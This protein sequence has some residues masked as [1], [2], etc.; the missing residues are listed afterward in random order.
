MSFSGLVQWGRSG[1][2]H[3]VLIGSSA[4]LFAAAFPNSVVKEGLPLL[5]FVA[6]V[7]VFIL[8]QSTSFLATVFWG[9]LYGYLSYAL[10]NY[11]L[12][13][14]HPLAGIVVGV[15][16]LTYFALLFPLLKLSEYLFPKKYYILQW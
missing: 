2:R 15:I 4:L 12:S 13:V 11:W 5:A 7:P 16:Y 6:Y 10:F 9:G 3:F 1:I 8:I 14:F